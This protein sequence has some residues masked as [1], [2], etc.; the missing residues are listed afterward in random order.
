[1]DSTTGLDFV[2][3]IV[4]ED[5]KNG[6]NESRVHT[7]FPPEP[8]G[9]LHIGHAKSIVLNFGISE[10]FNGKCNLRFDDTNPTKEDVEYVESIQEDIRWLG[11]DWEDR[12][13]FASDYFE[14]LYQWAEYLVTHGLAYVDELNAEQIREYRG[15]PTKA[16]KNSPFR[17]RPAEESLYLLRR[18]RGGEFP[19]GAMILRARIDMAHSNINM[20][21]PALYRIR[22]ARHHRTGTEWCIYP[23]YDF[24][25]GQSDAIEGITHSIC[26]LEFENHRPLYDWFIEQLP[27]PH[28]PRQ[29]EFARLNLTYTVMSKRKL[30]RLVQEGFVDGWDDP[31]MPTISGLRRRGYTP[32]AIRNFCRLIG[33]SKTNSTVDLSLLEFSLRE[34]L[35]VRARRYMAVTDPIKL[36]IT[37]WPEGHVEWFDAVNNPED[38]SQGSR[39]IPFTGNLYVERDDYL[40]DPPRKWF[41]LAK[42]KEVRLKHAYFVTCNDVVYDDEGNVLELLCTYDPESR[43]GESPDG[44]KVKGTLHWVTREHA[45]PAEIRFYEALFDRENPDD[46]EEGEDFTVALNPQSLKISRGYVEPSLAKLPEGEAVQF[47]R[48]GYFCKDRKYCTDDNLVFN[49]A[50]TLKDSWARVLRNKRENEK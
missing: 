26:T 38:D 20:R 33:V 41:R 7:R 21:D 35:N 29:I 6:K 1:M 28:T 16:G 11:F 25:H 8:N 18:M 19:D 14:Q 13:Y 31:R 34:D 17:D 50:V 9:Y 27:V 22:H 2:R 24:A 40:D 39:S 48:I 32:E 42:G 5:V 15:T 37:N 45:K 30:L 23:T 49:R 36:T 12:M 47:L 4:A 43:G 44:R 10:E 46:V 3:T